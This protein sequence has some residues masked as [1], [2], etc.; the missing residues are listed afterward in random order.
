MHQI[1]L[2]T[3]TSFLKNFAHEA[4]C[5]VGSTCCDDIFLINGPLHDVVNIDTT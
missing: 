4:G 5:G 2:H 3:L 1:V